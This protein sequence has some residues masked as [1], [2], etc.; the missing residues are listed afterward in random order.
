MSADDVSE[1]WSCDRCTE[2][3]FTAVREFL[4]RFDDVSVF[5]HFFPNQIYFDR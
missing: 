4:S 3:S 2:G 5:C 1:Q